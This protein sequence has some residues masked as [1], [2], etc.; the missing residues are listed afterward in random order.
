MLTIE[1]KLSVST[2]F[3]IQLNARVIVMTFICFAENKI[4]AS[5]AASARKNRAVAII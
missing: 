3:P 2:K 4:K 1:I 5:G